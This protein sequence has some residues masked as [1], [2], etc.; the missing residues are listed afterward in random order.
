MPNFKLRL[1]DALTES[2]LTISQ[3]AEKLQIPAQIFV[4]WLDGV[5][6]PYKT[7]W[8]DI[9]E[10]LGLQSNFFH[11]DT[12]NAPACFNVSVSDAAKALG[13]S[14]QFVAIGLQQGR[15]PWGWA[16]KLDE[17]SYFISSVKFSE[18][19][20]INVNNSK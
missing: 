9:A 18:Y 4:Q 17:W 2:D 19:T 3:A 16:V 1:Q 8:P 7:A 15:F 12:K 13:K 6:E 11:C 5:A 14:K 10:T 20:G